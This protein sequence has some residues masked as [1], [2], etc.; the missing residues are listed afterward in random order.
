MADAWHCEAD[1][2]AGPVVSAL[3]FLGVTRQKPKM[4]F[5]PHTDEEDARTVRLVNPWR[6]PT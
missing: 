3:G 1:D 4:V 2:N 6:S 5:P